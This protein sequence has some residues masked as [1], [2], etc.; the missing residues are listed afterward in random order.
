MVERS[1][2]HKTVT[3]TCQ[4]TWPTPIR[5]NATH[6]GHPAH[7]ELDRPHLQGTRLS[8]KDWAN[9]RAAAHAS[10]DLQR[11]RQPCS[12]LFCSVAG[13]LRDLAFARCLRKDAASSDHRSAISPAMTTS[14]ARCPGRTNSGCVRSLRRRTATKATPIM[15]TGPSPSAT[16]QWY[17]VHQHLQASCVID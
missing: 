4:F 1:T 5:Q 11:D 9:A 16:K 15:V 7:W 13:S 17:P 12:A 8:N 14:L 6:R 3:Q 2:L 10:M